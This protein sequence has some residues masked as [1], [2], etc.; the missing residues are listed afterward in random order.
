MK[1]MG[2]HQSARMTNDEWLTPPEI[3]SA[4]GSFDLD[5]CAPIVRPW[6]TAQNYFTIND[7]GLE[8][9]WKGRVWL[10]PPYG[11]MT[12][13]WLDRLA[14]HGNGIA[15][16][17]ARTETEMFVRNVWERADAI[18]FIHGRLYFHHVDGT[19]AKANSGAPS[20]LIAYGD[21]NVKALEKSGISGT[22]ISGWEITR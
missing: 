20:C 15:L 14:N 9:E 21:N 6:D 18:L 12:G 10:N 22:L 7:D 5:P 8:N 3:I 11:P 13:R 17:F 16:I 4:L 1:G 19:R 2:S